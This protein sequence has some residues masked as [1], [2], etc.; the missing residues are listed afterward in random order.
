[1]LR[2]IEHCDITSVISALIEIIKEFQEDNNTMGLAIK[3]LIK[4]TPD[5]SK[6]KILKFLKFWY[7]FIYY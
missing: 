1:M 2:I 5:L 3:W 6:K 7:K 4:T